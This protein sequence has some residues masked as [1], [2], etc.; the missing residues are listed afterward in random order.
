MEGIAFSTSDWQRIRETYTAW[1]DH[2]LARPL[3]YFTNVYEGGKAPTVPGHN[4]FLANYGLDAPLDLLIDNYLKT[5]NGRTFP[6]DSFPSWFLNFGAGVL[7]TALGARMNARPDT[8][9][10]EPA[11]GARLETTTIVFNED[12]PWWRKIFALAERAVERLGDV[13]Q[14]G[15]TDAGGNLDV[16][17]SLVGSQQLMIEV[18]DRPAEVKKALDE[19]TAV[20]I[21]VYDRQT[22]IIRK[23]CPGFVPWAP[24][25]APGTTYMLQS[26]AS[27]M[28]SPEMFGEFVMPDL[29]ACC[30]HLEY[31]FYHL[32][33]P[34]QIAHVDQLLSIENLRGIQWIPGDGQPQA[35]DWPELLGRILEAGRLVQ[36]FTTV[37]ATFKICRELGG[38]GTQ[39]MIRDPLT[40]AEADEVLAEI[41]R[42]S[43]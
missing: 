24:T 41:K 35:E 13:V 3:I 2:E 14:I 42:L 31:P 43:H 33:G 34:G 28:I 19:I 26:D 38:K 18:L 15:H 9:W 39:L 25:W 37:E 30:E 20:W 40:P 21:D 6:G 27:Y 32:D 16:L 22:K 29:V 17:A 36:A 12:D 10:F 11:D 1:W 5:Q 7:A 8:V 23:R 4:S